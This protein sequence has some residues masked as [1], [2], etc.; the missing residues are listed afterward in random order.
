MTFNFSN[1]KNRKIFE[2][3]GVTFQDDID[4][5]S[6]KRILKYFD[7]PNKEK[8]ANQKVLITYINRCT[9]LQTYP[10]YILSTTYY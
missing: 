2:E 9:L 3:R 6:E 10:L 7:H 1:N 5:I 4:A 8:Y